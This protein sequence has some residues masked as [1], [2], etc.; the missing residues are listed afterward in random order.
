MTLSIHPSERSAM[1][2]L[3]P[4]HKQYFLHRYPVSKRRI[5]PPSQE[6]ICFLL[7][8]IAAQ[9]KARVCAEQAALL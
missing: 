4:T 8:S 2:A 3:P 7:H 6:P 1:T 5:T 9:Q